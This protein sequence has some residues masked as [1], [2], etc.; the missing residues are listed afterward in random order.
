[1]NASRAT[2]LLL[3]AAV[4]LGAT[5]ARA[6]TVDWTL[7]AREGDAAPP[8]PSPHVF[9][10]LADVSVRGDGTVFFSNIGP[11]SSDPA[12]YRWSAAN[13]VELLTRLDLPDGP[14]G[15]PAYS[16][17]AGF[18][19]VGSQNE[20]PL[21]VDR[22]ATIDACPSSEL[23]YEATFSVSEAGELV[24]LV[25][26]GTPVPGLDPGWIFGW[27]QT[28]AISGYYESSYPPHYEP[29]PAV[30][31][32]GELAFFAGSV[33][34]DVCEA[35]GFDPY[36]NAVFGPDGNGGTALVAMPQQPEP[37]APAGSV[38]IPKN[39]VALNDLGDVAFSAD[40][41]LGPS[42]PTV[43]AIYRWN[44]LGGL[45]L[46]AYQYGPDPEG[47]TFSRPVFFVLGDGGHVVF[48]D[49]GFGGYYWYDQL[50]GIYVHD[51]VNGTRAVVRIGDQMPGL[52]PSFS[53]RAVNAF[54]VNARGE[55]A[56]SMQVEESTTHA[57]RWG[58]WG[59]NS[60]GNTA[61]RL[62]DGGLA[63][64]L[65]S[66]RFE[67]FEVLA[68]S[69]EREILFKA[70]LSAND[71]SDYAFY[72]GDVNGRLRLLLRNR[73]SHELGQGT[74]EALHF[75]YGRL[76]WDAELRHFAA[77]MADEADGLVIVS[78]EVPE[79]GALLAGAVAIAALIA[80]RRGGAAWLH[81]RETDAS[82]H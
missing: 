78:T 34:A 49:G 60:A 6:V 1:L 58:V 81:P 35:S 67:R 82:V 51:D 41:R 53:A 75:W 19:A 40:L 79:P 47:S 2:Q 63:P 13:G 69:D 15:D 37:D 74:P 44:A 55:V 52:P 33:H 20:G 48:L 39:S 57:L 11:G 3:A 5:H 26:P 8:V 64:G 56:F 36:A 21:L 4:A 7:V 73:D 27:G 59:P 45:Q 38:L 50:F 71:S 18:V 42:S 14:L 65:G 61:I 72:L 43:P 46:V 77:L 9:D 31:A 29:T 70:S 22:V 32:S 76:Q 16:I 30:N 62:I 68:L 80:A 54:A 12:L 24:P 23:T 10:T 66:A 25:Q 28:S 17:E